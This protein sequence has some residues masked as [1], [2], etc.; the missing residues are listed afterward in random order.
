MLKCVL[1]AFQELQL[2]YVF[3]FVHV[4]SQTDICFQIFSP[5]NVIIIIIIQKFTFLRVFTFYFHGYHYKGLMQCR[6]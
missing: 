2:L 6:Q 3:I 4:K 1:Y 5:V